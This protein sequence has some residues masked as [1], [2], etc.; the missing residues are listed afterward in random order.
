MKPETGSE[1]FQRSDRMARTTALGMDSSE[2][3]TAKEVA[4]MLKISPK[5]IYR[6]TAEGKIPYCKFESNVRFLKRE[7][8]VWI[9]EHNYRPRPHGRRPR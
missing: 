5:T 3:L 6:Y 8:L 7:I 2:M 1:N 9:E 4:K